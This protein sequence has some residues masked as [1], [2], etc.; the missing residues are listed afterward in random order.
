MNTRFRNSFLPI[1]GLIAALALSAS[2]QVRA[3]SASDRQVSNLLNHLEQ[4]TNDFKAEVS[5]AVDRSQINGTRREDNINALI[6]SFETSTDRL[7]TNF[8]MRR[9]A[10]ADVQDVLN[11]AAA[12]N[13]FM[14]NNSLSSRAQDLWTSIRSDLDTLAGYYSVRSDWNTGYYNGSGGYNN[15]NAGSGNGDRGY[16]NGGYNATASQMRSLVYRIQSRTNAFRTSYSRWSR[17][18]WRNQ[19][20]NTDID[21]RISDLDQAVTELNRGY[22]N[23]S[24]YGSSNVYAVFRP[25]ADINRFVVSTRTNT[26]L[27]NKWNLLRSDLDT[28]ATYYRLAW[29]WD[30]PVYPGD[31][32][33][34]GYNSGN[35]NNYGGFDARITGTYQLNTSQSDDVSDAINRAIGTTYNS[36]Q[37]DRTRR[38]LQRRL[39]SPE[40]IAIEKRGQQVT[41]ASTNAPSAVLTADNVARSETNAN[42]RT[43]NTRVTATNRDISIAYEGDRVNDYYIDFELVG[44]DQLRVT[45]RVY[46]EGQNK[47]VTVASVYDRISPTAQFDT[48]YRAPTITSG[49]PTTSTGWAIPNNTTITATLDNPVSTRTARNGDTFTMTVTSPSQYY[50]AV[51]TGRVAG[52]RSGVVAGRANL[53]FDFDT[54]RLRDGS[55]YQFA[56]IV[57]SVTQ[58]GG[59]IVSVNNEGQVRDKNQTTQTATR[60]GIGAA[61]GAIIGAIAGGG[62]GAAIGAGIGAGAG[63]G[64]VILQGR[65]DLDL[66]SGT[67]FNITAT[68]PTNLARERP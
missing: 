61:I 11:Q 47:Q 46:L 44:R 55:T 59:Q 52:D 43:V 1:L 60:A 5:R 32:T 67:Q 31:N 39:Q 22:S 51:I 38:N 49:Y 65:D 15:G 4:T 24:V 48:I 64:S 19:T 40:E 53:S 42:G 25:A 56:G 57:N 50:G 16:N 13:N 35:G 68:A 3:Y 54:I 10:S 21:Q 18:G 41:L 7:Q 8:N 23:T 17:Y 26:D 27:T 30:N 6:A 63:A 9:S 37:Q 34:G 28:L 66:S 33:Y 2:A 45:R 36:D 29:N 58:P 20:S 62:S 12:M 14:R